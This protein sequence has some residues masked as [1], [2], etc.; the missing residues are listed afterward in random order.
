M[1]L[2]TRANLLL[3][4]LN[5]T[6]PPSI[7]DVLNYYSNVKKYPRKLS[8]NDCTGYKIFKINVANHSRVLGE[9]NHFIISNVSDLLWKHSQPWQKFLYTDMAKRLR[10]LME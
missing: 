8:R 4:N 5:L 1:E 10:A 7:E 3:G 6:H 9:E 2:Q